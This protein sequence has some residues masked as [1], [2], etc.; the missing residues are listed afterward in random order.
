MEIIKNMPK[1]VSLIML[2]VELNMKME[3]QKQFG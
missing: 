1:D 2:I 3:S